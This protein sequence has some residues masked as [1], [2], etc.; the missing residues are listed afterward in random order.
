MAS[1][2][3]LKKILSF[4]VLFIFMFQMIPIANIKM[5][6]ASEFESVHRG[7]KTN[8]V[9]KITFNSPLLNSEENLK[10]VKMYDEAK[11]EIPLKHKVI[12]NGEILEVSSVNALENGRNYR[13]HI[14]KEIKSK[15]GVKLKEDIEFKFTTVKKFDNNASKKDRITIT[16]DAGQT[17]GN[18]VQ[19]F[20]VKASEVNLAVALKVGELLEK[21]GANVVYTRTT[22]TVSWGQAQDENKIISVNESNESDLFLSINCNLYSEERVKGIETY[23]LEGEEES[24]KLADQVQKSLISSTGRNNRGIKEKNNSKVLNEINS[25]GIMVHLG[26]LS[27]EEEAKLLSNKDYENKASRAIAEG[28][29]NYYGHKFDFGEDNNDQG[30]G[31][32]TEG[33]K[34]VVLNPA[35]V[36]TNAGLISSS[37]LT[38]KEVNLD[39]ILKTGKI[40]ESK[41]INV[42]YTIKENNAIWEDKTVSYNGVNIPLEIAERLKIANSSNANLM[43]TVGGNAASDP[44]VKGIE[45]YYYSGKKGSFELAKHVQD[46]IIQKSGADYR[47]V[48]DSPNLNTLK[49]SNSPSVWVATGFLSNYSEQELLSYGEYRQRIAQGMADGIMEYLDGIDAPDNEQIV[50]KERTYEVIKGEEFILPS[51]MSVDIDGTGEKIRTITWKESYVDTSRVGVHTYEGSVQGTNKKVRI[52]IIVEDLDNG[53]SGTGK[54]KVVID[55]GHGGFDPGAIGIT[56]SKEKEITLAVSLLVGDYLVKNGLEVVYTRSSDYIPWPNNERDDLK[57]RVEISNNE[58]PDVFVSI[59]ANKY[60]KETAHGIETYYYQG[61]AASEDLARRIQSNLINDTGRVDRGIKRGNGLYVVNNTDATSVLV[62]L[63]FISNPE[64]ESLLTD[65]T[66]QK[67]YAQSIAKGIIAHLEKR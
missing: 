24:S 66:Y 67:I 62:E 37:G 49:L 53:G 13:L 64:E 4:F 27:N 12:S 5:V 32:T 56:G 25:L 60:Y 35:R 15:N 57:A 28:I 11:R 7:I 36:G 65:P 10:N 34:T 39:I 31:G 43:V 59:H 16:V 21:A 47:G 23:Y 42:V 29:L 63:G 50:V 40:L 51:E 30:G 44:V 8:K 14:S 41:G 58:K 45:T 26:F 19:G 6:V 33:K 46:N 54:K 18:Y 1:N 52:T 38:E 17:F 48:I 61:S 2:S 20:G 55:P 9:W 22:P 3:R